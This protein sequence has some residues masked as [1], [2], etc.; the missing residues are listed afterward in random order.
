MKKRQKTEKL[1]NLKD[2][3]M[4]HFLGWFLP[5]VHFHLSTICHLSLYQEEVLVVS[6]TH[7]GVLEFNFETEMVIFGTPYSITNPN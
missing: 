3:M 4:S 6:K 2:G 5:S 7:K 1:I